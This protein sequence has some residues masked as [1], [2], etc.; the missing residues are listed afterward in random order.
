MKRL[1]LIQKAI[2]TS[3]AFI[4]IFSNIYAQN[5]N[6]ANILW[7]GKKVEA[8]DGEIVI[9]VKVGVNYNSFINKLHSI[10]FIILDKPDKNNIARLRIPNDISIVDAIEK[11]QQTNMVTDVTPIGVT[12]AYATT[13]DPYFG[14]QWGLQAINAPS[15]WDLTEGSSSDT[16][17]ILDSGIPFENNTLSH[18]DLQDAN[19]IL[20]GNDYTGDGLGIE[21]GLGHG[22]HVAGIISAETNNNTGVSGTTWNSII[23]IEKVFTYYN[24]GNSIWFYRAV[25]DAISHHVKVINY[26]GGQDYP[27]TYLEQAVQDAQKN[28]VIIVASSGNLPVVTS[29]PAAYSTSYNNV[30]AVSAT[31]KNDIIANFSSTGSYVTVSAPGVHVFSTLPNYPFYLQDLEPLNENY[32]YMDGT[33][34]SAPYVSGLA[35]LVLSMN[36]T[37]TPAQVRQLIEQNA[38]DLGATGFDNQYGYGRINALKTVA[39]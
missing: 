26:S 28:N 37:L 1:Y 5:F 19:R 13:N 22:T 27:D 9:K 10:H 4:I 32:D 16:I 14:N 30:I 7:K 29:W 34:M 39:M 20:I 23:Y 3:M 2:Y 25:D 17:G 15:A 33:S 6:K 38:D 21:D 11:V 36:P 24:V 8:V 18:P 31:D 12:H 35:S